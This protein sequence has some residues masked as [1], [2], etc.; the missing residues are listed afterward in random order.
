MIINPP[1]HFPQRGIQLVANSKE[2]LN[3]THDD[4]N[5]YT[6][7]RSGSQTRSLYLDQIK[8]VVVTFVIALHVPMA[9]GMG[10]FGIRLS[11]LIESDPLF[12]GF[13]TWYSYI[14]NSFIMYMMFL[15]SGYFVP[16]SVAKKG[17][18][19]YLKERL[20]R[21]GIPFLVGLLLINNAS[22]LGPPEK[23][24]TTAAQWF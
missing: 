3:R 22:Y 7:Q 19:R 18:L 15:I 24:K 21:L 23:L 13:F 9:F 10:W 17:V 16:R 8:A 4:T 20:I 6:N 1:K 5:A 11:G 2:Q 14:I 12:K